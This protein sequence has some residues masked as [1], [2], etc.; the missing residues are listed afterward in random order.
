MSTSEMSCAAAASRFFDQFSL[1]ESVLSATLSALAD[2]ARFVTAA[3]NLLEFDSRLTLLK[4][5]GFVRGIPPALKA[6]LDEALSR[7]RRIFDYRS[8]LNETILYGEASNDSES[9]TYALRRRHR[10][11]N[12]RG[13]ADDAQSILV[14]TFRIHTVAQVE[15]HI[16]ET[17][18][19]Q[20][21]MRAV[22]ERLE[23][24]RRSTRVS[25]PEANG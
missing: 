13:T 1:L 23:A 2:D 21:V 17:V 15:A 7:A 4:R 5:L 22:S 20:Q 3:E 11:A 12:G 18:A 6:E 24:H 10:Q 9:A 16:A 8:D 19:L 25:C 14:A